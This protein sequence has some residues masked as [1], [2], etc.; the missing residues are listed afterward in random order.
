MQSLVI[1]NRSA[2]PIVTCVGERLVPSSAIRLFTDPDEH[3]AA[4]R[5]GV[6]EMTVTGRGPFRSEIVRIDFQH[7][8]MQRF[9]ENMSRIR[10]TT[11][12]GGRA[13][14]A[15]PAQPGP[16]QSWAG[17]ELTS[18]NLIRHR[19]GGNYYQRSAGA[20]VTAAMSLPLAEIAALGTTF[21]GCDLSPPRDASIITPPPSAMARLRRLHAEAGHVAKTR[22]DIIA[23]PESARGLEQGLIEAMV[24]CLATGDSSEERAAQ[25]RHALIM[26]RFHRYVAERPNQPLYIPEVCKAIGV[27]ER[28]LR[29]CSQEQLGISPKQFLLMR[30][31]Q[32]ARRDLG[33]ADPKTTTVTEVATRYGFWQFGQFAGQYKSIFGELPSVTLAG[34]GG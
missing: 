13:V 5:Q 33:R 28:T 4:I 30:R 9:T 26:R 27:A 29:V 23:H 25:R 15:F 14:I 31:L 8:W 6:S 17:V 7:L 3:A 19:E 20:S 2:G 32:F 10:H 12:L 22:P 1:D 11:G 18:A 24:A 34:E 21:A 16:A